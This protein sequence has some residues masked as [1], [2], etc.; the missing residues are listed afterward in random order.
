MQFEYVKDIL[1]SDT[2]VPDL[3]LSDIMPHLPSDAVKVYLYCIF[4]SKY[5]K[6]VNLEDLAAKL[7]L[8]Y[9]AVKAAFVVLEQENLIL[10]DGKVV[11]ITN[12]KE[13]ELNKLY[14]KK[15]ATEPDNINEKTMVN[16]KRNQCIDSINRI[17]FQGLMA[18]SWYT[19]IDNWF[20]SYHF[21]E[22]VM[23]SLFK[24]CYDRNALNIKY[25]EKV[26]ATWHQRGITSHWELEKYMEKLEQVSR[27]G[28]RI[29]SILR[30]SRNITAYEERYIDTWI[31]EYNYDMPIIEEALKKTAG[32]TYPSFKYIHGILSAW[33]KEG[34]KTL[35]QLE[36]YL[37]VASNR[38][39]KQA[40]DSGKVPRRNN[41][42]QRQYD[43]DFYDKLSESTVTRK[44]RD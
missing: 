37:E 7:S 2:L 21:D 16:I 28:K 41:F 33:H 8:T 1:L 31:N 22:D 30:L 19:A 20:S 27:I 25:I 13:M 14:K 34:I 43:D 36:A 4:L 39:S 12:I 42:Q 3:F 32:K 35:D 23:V 10:R 9:D 44:E 40:K 18:P 6:Q 24:Y 26:G 17:F 15:T 5:N 29:A 38:G 11:T